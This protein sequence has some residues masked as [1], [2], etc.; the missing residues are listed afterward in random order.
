[1]SSQLIQD[2]RQSDEFRQAV[3]L[4]DAGPARIGGFWGGA[5]SFFLGAWMEQD[6]EKNGYCVVVTSCQEDADHLL[7]EIETF[8]AAAAVPFP[9]WESLFQ[10]DS[11]PDPLVYGERLHVLERL[12]AREGGGCIVTPIH[13]L[14]QP[15][16]QPAVLGKDRLEI[17]PGF[18][19]P[20]G[21][22]AKMLTEKGYRNVRLA[23]AAGEF[24]SRGDIFDVF[25]HAGDFPVRLEYFGDSIES[26]R[27]YDPAS[28]RSLPD[29]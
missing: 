19:L 27:R 24:S 12:M 5:L 28:Q 6:K 14:I 26:I 23:E 3:D 10:P 15:V 8:A 11:R 4:L 22:L 1:M 13:A 25:A 18:E 21:E 16:P 20:P 9:A 17:R 29:C 2:Y 7:E